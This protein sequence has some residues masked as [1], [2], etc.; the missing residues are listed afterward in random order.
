MTRSQQGEEKGRYFKEGRRA[1]TRAEGHRRPRH[2]IRNARHRTQHPQVRL[3]PKPAPHSAT[4]TSLMCSRWLGPPSAVSR[5]DRSALLSASQRHFSRT[6]LADSTNAGLPRKLAAYSR[7][8][9]YTC[10]RGRVASVATHATPRAR[11]CSGLGVFFAGRLAELFLARRAHHILSI[12]LA[13]SIRRRI[14]CCCASL[15]AMG[16]RTDGLGSCVVPAAGFGDS[17]MRS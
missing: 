11:W 7:V 9:S 3:Q 14:V 2:R 16:S 8:W 12:R 15:R 13:R 1:I 6:V 4:L 10:G 5:Q 17:S